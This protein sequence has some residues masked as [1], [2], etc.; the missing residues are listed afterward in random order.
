MVIV[1]NAEQFRN[2]I[3]AFEETVEL[4]TYDPVNLI[5]QTYKHIN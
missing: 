1:N 2:A 5:N 4:K 3:V